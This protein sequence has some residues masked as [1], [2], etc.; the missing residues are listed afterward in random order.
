VA[1]TYRYI[2]EILLSTIISASILC[3]ELSPAKKPTSISKPLVVST[4]TS[5][6]QKSL[7]KKLI[8]LDPGHDGTGGQGSGEAKAAS[9]LAMAIKK[10]LES[11]PRFDVF[12]THSPESYNPLVGNFAR[13]NSKR[14]REYFDFFRSVHFPWLGPR[15]RPLNDYAILLF[16]RAGVANDEWAKDTKHPLHIDSDAFIS[17]HYNETGNA[18]WRQG[19]R[20]ESA[21]GFCVYHPK[22]QP[23]E[24][25]L[26]PSHGPKRVDESSK[27]AILIRDELIKVGRSKS[28]VKHESLGVY[29]GKYMVLQPACAPSILL[30]AGYIYNPKDRFQ[31]FSH[32]Q[33][34][35]YGVYAGVCRYF[36]FT[37]KKYSPEPRLVSSQ[38]PGSSKPHS[39]KPSY[40]RKIRK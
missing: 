4:Q 33:T 21:S 37:P 19:H 1:A 23:K 15:S 36:G 9:L 27:L 38:K 34:T 16:S 5:A 7:Q 13:Q 30:E 35:A 18:R 3:P 10:G 8:I 31:A 32:P 22:P 25:D 6:D 11:D 28:T 26:H 24:V 2:R 39:P 17:L 29:Q 20:I 12:L 14:V 40:A